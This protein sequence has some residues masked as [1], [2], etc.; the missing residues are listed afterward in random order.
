MSRI[1]LVAN[2]TIGRLNNCLTG[3]LENWPTV[4]ER[5]RSMTTYASV[6]VVVLC[7]L[8]AGPAGAATVSGQAAM[9]PNPFTGAAMTSEVAG[10][11]K[12]DAISTAVGYASGLQQ[13]S[14]I[15]G[16]GTTGW[17]QAVAIQPFTV[18]FMLTAQNVWAGFDNTPAMITDVKLGD[19]VVDPWDGTK[20]VYPI[21]VQTF[22][23]PVT[24]D[25]LRIEFQS[26][27]MVGTTGYG[28]FTKVVTIPDS[29]ERIQPTVE[30]SA[31]H[32]WGDVR[33]LS[34]LNFANDR[35]W[36]VGTSGDRYV[37]L[38]LGGAQSVAAFMFFTYPNF[39]AQ[40]DIQYG[41]GYGPW[42]TIASVTMN[43]NES[44][45]IKLNNPI[46]TEKIKLNFTSSG[47]QS[48]L[49]EAVI[50]AKTGGITEFKASDLASGNYHFT[51]TSTV[52]ISLQASGAIDGYKVTESD[53][54][55]ASWDPAPPTTYTI[56]GGQGVVTL[57]GWVKTSS[58]QV[59]HETTE[60]V[61]NTNPAVSN[62]Q[63]VNA[64][65]DHVDVTWD[66]D[67]D[68]WG[69][70]LYMPADQFDWIESQWEFA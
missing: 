24:T 40:F 29:F 46:T 12:G 1:L 32:N 42:T 48:A 20:G 22:E 33:Y 3:E 49:L 68:T 15:S 63:F 28:D 18:G 59:L 27:G 17:M 36:V 69:R 43:T 55:P 39:G 35:G 14:R 11:P 34:D 50:L 60:I 67:V 5:G 65:D 44:I 26:L 25:T 58:G 13:G 10:V 54:E 19:Q 47:S 9:Y 8:L 38:D 70:V 51:D 31:G 23:A 16:T 56:T 2:W 64:A 57:H 30:S 21:H 66:T 37:V 45:P 61:Y 62:V 41:D 53:V 6:L 7:F 4:D 52:D